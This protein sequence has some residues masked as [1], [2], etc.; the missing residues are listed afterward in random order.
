[1]L[2]KVEDTQL[3]DR[4][5][6]RQFLKNVMVSVLSLGCLGVFGFGYFDFICMFI[7]VDFLFVCGV[8][9]VF[10]FLFLKLLA[11]ITKKLKYHQVCCF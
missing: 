1:M 3:T 9:L 4:W 7:L 10:C 6:T 2:A 11:S 5:W 8:F